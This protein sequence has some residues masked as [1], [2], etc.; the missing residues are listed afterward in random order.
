MPEKDF[1]RFNGTSCENATRN[2]PITFDWTFQFIE[3]K[4]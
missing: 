4:I 1:M 3:I 2:I